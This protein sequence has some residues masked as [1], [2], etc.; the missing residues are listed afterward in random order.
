MKMSPFDKQRAR[1][2][3]EIKTRSTDKH[4]LYRGLI[5][6]KGEQSLINQLLEHESIYVRYTSKLCT[7][8][9]YKEEVANRL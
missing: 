6:G 5:P 4:I 3:I 8:Y 1:K 9:V 7:I 2:F